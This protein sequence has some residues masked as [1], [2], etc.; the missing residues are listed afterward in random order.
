MT[1]VITIND[2]QRYVID[3]SV[4]ANYVVLDGTLEIA[5]GGRLTGDGVTATVQVSQSGTLL[6]NG[7]TITSEPA[8]SLFRAVVYVWG[9]EVRVEAGSILGNGGGDL[10]ASAILMQA[11]EHAAVWIDGGE[12]TGAYGERGGGIGVFMMGHTGA[13]V[14]SVDGGTIT[15]GDSGG[16]GGPALQLQ[17]GS[18]PDANTARIQGGRFYSG[19]GRNGAAD[20][21]MTAGVCELSIGGG[22]FGSA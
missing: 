3:T 19:H 16:S 4:A 12:V 20:A 14:L 8:E 18:R 1:E 5:S 6:V 22:T 17:A 15:G 21:I 7:G 10:G 9:G 11:I 13:N 2:G